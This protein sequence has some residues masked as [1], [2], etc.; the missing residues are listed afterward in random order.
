MSEATV[1]PVEFISARAAEIRFGR[2][3]ATVLL[4][5]FSGIG[6]VFG[7]LWYGVAFAGVAV[8]YGFHKGARIQ[9][10]RKPQQPEPP[11]KPAAPQ[12]GGPPGTFLEQ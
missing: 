2:T 1:D 8:N 11:L 7:T 12:R 4:A 5:I 3:V 6:W 9:R 10:E